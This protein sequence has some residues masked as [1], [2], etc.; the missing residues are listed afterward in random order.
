MDLECSIDDAQGD[1]IKPVP[2]GCFVHPL[3]LVWGQIDEFDCIGPDDGIVGEVEEICD[4]SPDSC[5]LFA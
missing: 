2:V 5:E 3:G 1:P 4:L